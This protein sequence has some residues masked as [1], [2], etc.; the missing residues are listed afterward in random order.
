LPKLAD[1]I[2]E[3]CASVLTRTYNAARFVL[4]MGVLGFVLRGRQ[5]TAYVYQM[6]SVWDN[7]T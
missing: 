6:I 3:V 4:D 1:L 5:Y 7:Q 2:F